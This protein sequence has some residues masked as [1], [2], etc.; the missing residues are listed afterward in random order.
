MPGVATAHL[1]KIDDSINYPVRTHPKRADDK[2]KAS[3]IAKALEYGSAFYK[4]TPCPHWR[5]VKAWW[6]QNGRSEFEKANT[7]AISKTKKMLAVL[8]FKGKG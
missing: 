2:F 5:P 7:R 6:R 3:L 1:V 8:G 4:V